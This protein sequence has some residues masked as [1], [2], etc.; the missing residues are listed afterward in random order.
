LIIRF[1]KWL[2]S[3]NIESKKRPT[4]SVV[5]NIPQLKR[6]EQ[7]IY[8]PTDLWTAEDDLLFLKYCPSK[9]IKCY[10][11]MSSDLSARPSEILGLRIKDITWKRIE[12]KQYAEVLLNG[13]T[14]SRNLLLIDSI[15][16]LKDYMNSEHPQPSNSNSMLICGTKRSCGKRIAENTLLM[17]YATLYAGLPERAAVLLDSKILTSSWLVR[18]FSILSWT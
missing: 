3:P 17:I 12:D 8:R 14:G 4:P 5:E 13:K 1:F 6:K 16:Y 15:P 2:H 18:I 11:T 7:S 9:R 10:H